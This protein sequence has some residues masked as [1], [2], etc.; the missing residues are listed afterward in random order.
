MPQLV[1]VPVFNFGEVIVRSTDILHWKHVPSLEALHLDEME[2]C[3]QLV[4]LLLMTGIF[5]KA[6]CSKYPEDLDKTQTA[7]LL[8]LHLKTTYRD[9]VVRNVILQMASTYGGGLVMKK[10]IL[11]MNKAPG[12]PIMSIRIIP[13]LNGLLR[14]K[15]A[16]EIGR[17]LI[18][19]VIETFV[20]DPRDGRETLLE[21]IK[22]RN[23]KTDQTA[24]SGNRFS[25]ETVESMLEGLFGAKAAE[26]SLAVKLL[27]LFS[28]K[29]KLMQIVKLAMIGLRVNEMLNLPSEG[30]N[31]AVIL[32]TLPRNRKEALFMSAG[33][34]IAE[35]AGGLGQ[36]KIVESVAKNIRE[37]IYLR[38][39]LKRYCGEGSI[40][41]EI[42]DL[43]MENKEYLDIGVRYAI[44]SLDKRKMALALTRLVSDSLKHPT[45]DQVYSSLQSMMTGSV[46]ISPVTTDKRAIQLQS[47]KIAK[48]DAVESR[49][50]KKIKKILPK[51]FRHLTQSWTEGELGRL[52]GHAV[53][54]VLTSSHLETL[55]V[56]ATKLNVGD[57]SALLG[58]LTQFASSAD[59]GTSF[60]ANIKTKLGNDSLES[61]R[62]TF[63]NYLTKTENDSS[64]DPTGVVNLSEVLPSLEERIVIIT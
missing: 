52:L 32:S 44:R 13:V 62:K 39:M 2:G 33:D 15:R 45:V 59:E 41:L 35:M 8:G 17:I 10:L 9:P 46:E 60:F 31:P 64:S 51:M 57:Q 4:L 49:R 22:V 3:K 50:D 24:A 29:W 58:K 34:V 26:S 43:L 42:P 1:V 53:L 63:V 27:Q 47:A 5:S 55:T 6:L 61:I 14:A 25:P 36:G 20:L 16:P 38:L 23:Q 28:D 19:T 11:E 18:K 21:E 7:L 30:R 56:L 48:I 40:K 37:A 12:P 54:E